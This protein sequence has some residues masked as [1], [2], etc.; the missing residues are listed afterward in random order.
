LL[1]QNLIDFQYRDHFNVDYE[2]ES[3]QVLQC[4]ST[5]S[6]SWLRVCL[7]ETSI[8]APLR[9]KGEKKKEISFFNKLKEIN[10]S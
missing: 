6:S 4:T 1:K 5:D 10:F 3:D 7:E 8:L 2:V 9:D